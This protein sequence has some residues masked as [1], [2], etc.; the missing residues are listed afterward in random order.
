M[1]PSRQLVQARLMVTFARVVESG[2]ISMAATLLNL[3]KAG[4]SRQ[5]SE[6]EAML[7]V[8]LLNRSTRGL[9]LTDVG[10]MVYERAARIVGEL[11]ST[12]TE[13]E[14]SRS[15]PSG[16]L[17][18]STSVA[19]G[20]AHLVPYLGAFAKVHP[21]IK[22][23]L[24]LLDRHVDPFEEG[25]EV[26]LRICDTP[27]ENMV[28]SKLADIRYVLVAA[29]TLLNRIDPLT[30]PQD[31]LGVS[32]LFYGFRKHASIW[33]FLSGNSFT[34]VPVTT[35]ISVNSSEAV[36]NLALQGLGVALLPRFAVYEDLDSGALVEVLPQHI[37]QGYLGTGLYALYPSSRYPAPKLRAFL[38]FIKGAWLTDQNWNRP[39][40]ATPQL[41]G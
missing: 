4:I 10:S 21:E 38:D 29:P 40:T 28:A 12:Q 5:I 22:I 14:H 34:E 2:S 33:R 41:P 13:A 23:D 9:C 30:S 19:F 20:V 18:V 36:K 3:D 31:L 1:N 32:C 11:E 39:T 37:P 25:I 26:L 8:K 6:L 27:P 17:S 15:I 24:C 16:V 7:G 35:S